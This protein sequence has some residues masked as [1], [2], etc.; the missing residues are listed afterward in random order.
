VKHVLRY[1]RGIFGHGIRYTSIIDMIWHEYIDSDWVGNVANIK[2]T[3]ECSFTLGSS[4]LSWC[5]RKWNY[6]SLITTKTK[7]IALS[8][9]FH[10]AVWLRKILADLFKHV[11]DSTIIHYGNQ[12]CL[13]ISDNPMFHDKSNQIEIKYDYIRD[14]VHRKEVLVMYL[15]IDEKVVDILTKPA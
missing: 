1:Q 7:Y 10:E 5:S 13:K 2:S 4:M 12:I 11:L 3:F 14:M 15:P 9:S 8:M 6:V